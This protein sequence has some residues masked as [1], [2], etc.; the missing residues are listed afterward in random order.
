MAD[1][2]SF[3]SEIVGLGTIFA[4][5]YTNQHKRQMKIFILVINDL[6]HVGYNCKDVEVF[7]EVKKATERM[8][9]LYLKACEEMGVEDPY[10]ENTLNN[11]FAED[12]YAYVFGE[13]YLDIFEKEV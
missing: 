7:T 5:V 2:R 10:A 9:E 3:P 13:C 6:R 4:V 12:S 1:Y 8:R 11:A